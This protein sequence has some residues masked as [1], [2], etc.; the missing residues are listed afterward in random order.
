MDDFWQMLAKIVAL[1]VVTFATWWAYLAL[2]DD[3]K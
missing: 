2:F 3:G 1:I